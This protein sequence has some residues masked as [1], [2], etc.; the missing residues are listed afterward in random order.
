VA[1]LRIRSSMAAAAAGPT[2]DERDVGFVLIL[3]K[4]H[5]TEQQP[6]INNDNNKCTLVAP[7]RLNPTPPSSTPYINVRGPIGSI[8]AHTTRAPNL[9]TV[10]N[11]GKNTPI[12]T[13]LIG[14]NYLTFVY[15][16]YLHIERS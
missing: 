7:A 3:K 6:H 8:L 5:K 10:H 11:I 4:C 15:D 13:I 16:C 12:T 14:F 9:S 2:V 1:T